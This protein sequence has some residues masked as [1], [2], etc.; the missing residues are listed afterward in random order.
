MTSQIVHA[1]CFFQIAGGR[2]LQTSM[3]GNG[4][5]TNVPTEFLRCEVNFNALQPITE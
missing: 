2:L 1:F 3:W 5:Q 4:F